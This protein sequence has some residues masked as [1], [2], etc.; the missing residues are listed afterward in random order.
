MG[1]ILYGCNT[2]VYIP[3]LFNTHRFH[4]QGILKDWS[5]EL[6][7]KNEV[8][9][10]EEIKQLALTFNLEV[11]D[12]GYFMC[13]S[14]RPSVKHSYTKGYFTCLYWICRDLL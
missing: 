1:A 3:S 2:Y 5:T 10:Y 8:N 7:G 4:I 11:N 6:D 12:L 9:L 14:T 13:M